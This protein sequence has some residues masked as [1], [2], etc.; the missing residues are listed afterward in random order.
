MV[1]EPQTPTEFPFQLPHG[2]RDSEGNLHREG[3]MRMATAFDEIGPLKDPRVQSNPGFL[4][5]ILLA[6]VITRLGT[7]EHLHPKIIEG[8]LSA[9]L[10]YLQEFYRR[11]NDNGHSR[12]LVACP[13]C[14]GEFEVETRPEGEP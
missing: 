7:L 8:L 4:V 14:E 11:I 3:T 1:A 12:L 13:H 6:R 5:I 2:Y 9:D 10:L